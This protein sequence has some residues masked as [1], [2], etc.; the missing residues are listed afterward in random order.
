MA[1]DLFF[2]S[3]K[4]R[5]AGKEG[6]LACITNRLMCKYPMIWDM[7]LICVLCMRAGLGGFVAFQPRG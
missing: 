4:E 7:A 2:P 3:S 6:Y 5:S 1:S